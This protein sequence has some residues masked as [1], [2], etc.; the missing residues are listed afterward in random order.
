MIRIW[1]KYEKNTKIT[2]YFIHLH[3]VASYNC[4]PCFWT[5]KGR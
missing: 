5:T 2:D 3:T 1:L 4:V